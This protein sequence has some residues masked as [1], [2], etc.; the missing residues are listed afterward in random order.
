M[1]PSPL[2]ALFFSVALIALHDALFYSLC[3][4]SVL[5]SEAHRRFHESNNF[6][7][8]SVPAETPAP[9]TLPSPQT[10]FVE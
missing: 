5:S 2:P 3:L 8:F 6:F 1:L 10:V 7:V 9:R 4:S